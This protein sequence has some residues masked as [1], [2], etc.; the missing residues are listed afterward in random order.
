VDEVLVATDDTRIRDAVNAF[1]GTAVMTRAD[2]P[3]GTDRIAEAVAGR[4]GDIVVNLQGDEP[5]MPPDIIDRL[6]RT[7]LAGDAEMATVAVPF[8]PEI[9]DPRD[10]NRVKVVVDARGYALYFSR[11]CIPYLREGGTAVERLWHWGLYAYRRAFL[12]QFVRWPQTRLE[13]CEKLEQLRALEN[14]A[15]IRVV[16]CTPAERTVA[17]DTP[18]DLAEVTRIVGQ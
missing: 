8:T 13:Q 17:V 11:A 12:E 18:E 5:L 14:G 10:P 2:H 7:M 16:V 3:S 4:D 6:V 15:R 9:G 1:G